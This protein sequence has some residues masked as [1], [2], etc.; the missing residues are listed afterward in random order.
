MERVFWVAC[1]DC[2]GRFYG[3]YDELRH[4]RIALFC[5]YCHARFLPEAAAWLDDRPDPR[6]AEAAL[7]G[8]G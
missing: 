1:P 6:D 5:P 8:R 7:R 4:A 3:N 2:Q